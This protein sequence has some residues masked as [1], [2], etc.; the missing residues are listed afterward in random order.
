MRSNFKPPITSWFLIKFIKYEKFFFKQRSTN[1]WKLLWLKAKELN[2]Y[3]FKLGLTNLVQHILNFKKY[4]PKIFLK[5]KNM[6]LYNYWT[7]F[8]F[9]FTNGFLK[10]K[11]FSRLNSYATLS[12]ENFLFFSWI[13]YITWNTFNE[14]KIKNSCNNNNDFLIKN[15]FLSTFLFDSYYYIYE[16]NYLTVAY[17][18]NVLF[19]NFYFFLFNIFFQKYI[20]KKNKPEKS[21]KFR[22]TYLSFKSFWKK[23]KKTVFTQY[24][25]SW[26]R[27]LSLYYG[28]KINISYIEDKFEFFFKKCNHYLTI[29]R[30]FKKKTRFFINWHHSPSAT[31]QYINQKIIFWLNKFFSIAN[32]ITVM[33]FRKKKIYSKKKKKEHIYIWDWRMTILPFFVN[34]IFY[35]HNG[36]RFTKLWIVPAMLGYKFGEFS[37][38]WRICHKDPKIRSTFWNILK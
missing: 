4:F 25:F 37:F 7:S 27:K 20:L 1:K 19:F 10:N 26:I 30:G 17:S 34:K 21:S 38:T 36:H 2:V 9:F 33:F 31:T 23:K 18:Q 28:N 16:K 12:L 11:K 3:V 15:F 35:I 13:K 6:I 14:Q 29:Q 5:I 8:V 24:Y 32:Y 22:S